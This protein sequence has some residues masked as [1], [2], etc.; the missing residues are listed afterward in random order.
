[1]TV[2]DRYEA[3]DDKRR[4]AANELGDGYTRVANALAHVEHRQYKCKAHSKWSDG[5]APSCVY[6]ADGT[7][8]ENATA[9]PDLR[10][11]GGDGKS[12]LD[13][14]RDGK[15]GQPKSARY[16]GDAETAPAREPK[17]TCTHESALHVSA[18]RCPVQWPDPA[19]ETKSQRC[20]GTLGHAGTHD[21]GYIPPRACV[22]ASCVCT[23]YEPDSVRGLNSDP[24]GTA[25]LIPDRA[26]AD[27]KRLDKLQRAARINLDEQLAILAKYG[28]ARPASDA[29]RAQLAKANI[30][31]E[32]GCANCGNAKNGGHFQTVFRR[33]I[34]D[35]CWRW[36]RDTGELPGKRECDAHALYPGKPV[37][38]PD[39][40]HIHNKGSAA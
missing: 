23:H 35:F 39:K 1:M 37:R 13:R 28:Q 34:C 30:R 17:C 6:K 25:A 21:L 32:P 14:M 27:L 4:D 11:V 38:R 7:I 12:V 36:E 22:L 24:T 26:N 5:S 18:N 40:N 33:G 15:T 2:N 10:H 16:D 8:D 19:D 31:P 29:D 3:D 20:T 9:C